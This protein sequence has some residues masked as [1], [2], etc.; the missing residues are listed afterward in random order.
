M[1]AE[2]PQKPATPGGC[3]PTHWSPWMTTKSRPKSFSDAVV[4]DELAAFDKIVQSQFYR[5]AGERGQIASR[6]VWHLTRLARHYEHRLEFDV[7]RQHG[8]SWAGFR[9]MV[10]TYILGTAEPAQLARIL[11][12]SR[13]TISAV[14]ERLE[15]DGL[16]RRETDASNRTRVRVALTGKGRRAVEQVGTPHNLMEQSLVKSLQPAE[17]AVL[18]DLLHKLLKGME[19]KD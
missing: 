6:I 14:L 9:V 10:N 3:A 18:S 7:H 19:D 8:W 1:T 2:P 5:E 16:I 11:G 17:Q 12:V 4:R 13:P 15:R